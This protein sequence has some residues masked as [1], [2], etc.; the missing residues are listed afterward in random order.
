[1]RINFLPIHPGKYLAE[2]LEELRISQAALARVLGVSPMRISHI[3][4]CGRPVTAE[5]ALLFGKAFGQTP[6]CWLN[7]QSL[8]DLKSAEAKLAKRLKSVRSI[9]ID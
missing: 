2:L 5:M 8:H 4:N 3:V 9:A 7:L 6:R 1:M